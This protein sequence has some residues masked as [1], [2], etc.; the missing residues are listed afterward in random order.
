MLALA[1]AISYSRIYAGVHYPRDVAA[2]VILGIVCG[3][4]GAR[5]AISQ[6]QC[7]RLGHPEKPQ[8]T[9]EEISKVEYQLKG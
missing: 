4:I 1:T 2:G 5:W 9:H 6:R 7:G 3:W 8:N